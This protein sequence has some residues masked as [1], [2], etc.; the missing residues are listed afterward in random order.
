MEIRQTSEFKKIYKKLHPNQRA[1][2]NEE[3]KK[4]VENPQIEIE[5]S[6]D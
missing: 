4:I 2:V 5:K 1:V 3:I 6:G